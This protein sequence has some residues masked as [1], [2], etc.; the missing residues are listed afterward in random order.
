M[1]QPVKVDARESTQLQQLI[2][3]PGEEGGIIT[4]TVK[5]CSEEKLKKKS[6]DRF[7]SMIKRHDFVVENILR[8][9][10]IRDLEALIS[11]F[12]IFSSIFGLN[13]DN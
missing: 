3:R 13:T 4:R 5:F 6:A 12:Q 7:I 9:E 8:A 10:T 2:T 1:D 11:D